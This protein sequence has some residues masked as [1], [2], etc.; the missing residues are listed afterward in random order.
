MCILQ[1]ITKQE[2]IIPR[3]FSVGRPSI[4]LKEAFAPYQL[5]RDDFFFPSHRDEGLI[6]YSS[7]SSVIYYRSTNL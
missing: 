2:K 4:I 7:L 1:I 6:N 3:T 5:I